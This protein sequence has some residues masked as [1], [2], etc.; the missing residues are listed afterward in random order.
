MSSNKKKVFVKKPGSKLKSGNKTLFFINKSNMGH[1]NDS[2]MELS[3]FCDT[4]QLND[5]DA[6]DLNISHG[7][8]IAGVYL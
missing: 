3:G 5:T 7:K 1:I 2:K 8:F 6:P 4:V